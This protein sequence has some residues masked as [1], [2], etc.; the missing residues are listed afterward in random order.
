MKRFIISEDEKKHILKLYKNHLTEST[1]GVEPLVNKNQ[2]LK[3]KFY[4]NEGCPNYRCPNPIFY[5]FVGN[6]IDLMSPVAK[7][8]PFNPQD[9]YKQLDYF[10]TSTKTGKVL[11]QFYKNTKTPIPSNFIQIAMGTSSTPGANDQVA[12]N[13]KKYVMSYMHYLLFL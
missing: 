10:L 1:L 5:W 4:F 11:Q 13:R 12:E 7:S 2:S 9:I 3:L 6:G 8:L